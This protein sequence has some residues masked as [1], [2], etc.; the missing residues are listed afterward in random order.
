MDQLTTKFD[1]VLV[2]AIM[3]RKILFN[4]KKMEKVLK[5][6]GQNFFFRKFIRVVCLKYRE[7]KR[8]RIKLINLIYN[9]HIK[10]NIDCGA[11]TV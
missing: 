9:V 8:I 5:V 1:H 11:Q 10:I 2:Y 7:T 6:G 3:F 4:I